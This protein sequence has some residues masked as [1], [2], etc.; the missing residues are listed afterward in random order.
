MPSRKVK[1]NNAQDN[2]VANPPSERFSP[3]INNQLGGA[4][5]EEI[6]RR[7]LKIGSDIHKCSRPNFRLDLKLPSTC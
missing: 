6:H 3:A 7:R 5:E 1:G 2:D 4:T